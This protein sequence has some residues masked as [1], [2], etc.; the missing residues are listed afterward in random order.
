[1]KNLFLA[2]IDSAIDRTFSLGRAGIKSLDS[3]ALDLLSYRTEVEETLIEDPEFCWFLALHFIRLRVTDRL[4]QPWLDYP[5]WHPS[6][7]LRRMVWR[8]APSVQGFIPTKPVE[9]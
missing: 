8:S 4:L 3:K 7:F 6:L 1:M 5:D 2:E 9:I